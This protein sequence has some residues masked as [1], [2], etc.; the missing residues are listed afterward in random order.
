MRIAALRSDCVRVL[1]PDVGEREVGGGSATGRAPAPAFSNVPRA[2]KGSNAHP[3]MVLVIDRRVIAGLE[4]L[5]WGAETARPVL[6]WHGMGHMSAGALMLN[7][8]GPQWAESGLRIL[9]PNA[10]GF[11]Q[12]PQ[13]DDYSVR[14]M[15]TRAVAVL[16]ELGVDRVSFVGYSWGGRVGLRLPPNRV[17]A[18]VLLDTGYAAQSDYGTAE[19]LEASFAVDWPAWDSWDELFKAAR[20]HIAPSTASTERLQAAFVERD[21]RIVPRVEPRMV[22]AALGA[23]RTEPD[24]EWW[25]NWRETPILLLTRAGPDEADL[26]TFTA[27]LPHVEVRR[28]PRAGHDVL[29]DNPE[30]VVPQVTRF[31]RQN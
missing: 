25:P 21:G 26:D 16:D 22:A 28:V 7:E 4:V 27:A 8:V 6:Y 3:R 19:E 18:L 2:T 14:A 23:I 24:G 11:G 15:A 31:L 13:A 9:A 29:S 12:S 1:C 30:F 20:E 17:E 5:G 10:P